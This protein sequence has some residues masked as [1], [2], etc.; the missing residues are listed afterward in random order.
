MY[1]I[2]FVLLISSAA[3][4]QT[5]IP[6]PSTA[7]ASSHD[8]RTELWA[9]LIQAFPNAAHIDAYAENPSLTAVLFRSSGQTLLFSLPSRSVTVVS[10]AKVVGRVNSITFERGIEHSLAFWYVLRLNGQEVLRIGA[11][12]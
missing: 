6:T 12:E 10:H 11:K 3:L 2:L 1:R 7:R 4:A 9:A 8:S 5:G